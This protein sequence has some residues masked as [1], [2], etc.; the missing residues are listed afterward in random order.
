M[1]TRI[2]LVVVISSLLFINNIYSQNKCRVKSL[3]RITINV[4]PTKSGYSKGDLDMMNALK[5]KLGDYD[6]QFTNDIEKADYEFLVN[7]KQLND[8]NKI[9]ASVTIIEKMPK[10]VVEIGAKGEAFYKVTGEV[11][12]VDLTELGQSIRETISA[13]YMR[14]FGSITNYFVDKIDLS[15]SE[16]F[17]DK[18]IREFL[19]K[20]INNK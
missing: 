16:L 9:I 7:T 12:P 15:E 13:E 10:E 8:E 2:F 5:K 6:L 4:I 17:C 14:N 11:K 3:C 20:D 18:A 1:S 19:G